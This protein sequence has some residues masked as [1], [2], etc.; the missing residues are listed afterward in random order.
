MRQFPVALV[1]LLAAASAASAAEIEARS[2]IDAVIVYPDGATVT[3]S[4]ASICR[5]VTACC[6]PATFRPGST[7]LRCAWKARPGRAW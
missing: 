5:M 6:A 1:L 4:Y 3:A 7:R 2:D